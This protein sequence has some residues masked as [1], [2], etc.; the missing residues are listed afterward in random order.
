MT[1]FAEFTTVVIDC[2]D[3]A[4][5]AEFYRAVTGWDVTYRD[6]ECVQL[7]NGGPIQLGFQRVEDYQPP[8]WP[9][10]AKHAHLDLK[11]S[12][13]DH[14][15]KELLAIGAAKPAF[16]PGGDDWVVLLDP[17]GH[18]FCLVSG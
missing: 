9:G 2:T 13:L 15:V 18:P 14:T 16:Q 10:P 7:G 17:A 4:P 12:D 3:P 1:A 8:V 11:V 6:A 5:L